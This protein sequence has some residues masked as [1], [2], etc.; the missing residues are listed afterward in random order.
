MLCG[1]GI[2]RARGELSSF[3]N[4]EALELFQL[5]PVSIIDGNAYTS[6]PGPRV[7]DGAQRIR[8]ALAGKP[9]REVER[10]QP[11]HH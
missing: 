1:F 9:S 7:V 8:W 6:R 11:Q 3:R 5:V 4:S 10:W 2:Q